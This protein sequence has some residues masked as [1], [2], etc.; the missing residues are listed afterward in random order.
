MTYEPGK[1]A[2]Y[3]GFSSNSDSGNGDEV[4]L[5]EFGN[6]G[7]AKAEICRR[8]IVSTVVSKIDSTV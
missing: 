6:S 4:S 8:R 7:Y 1:H 3:D 2:S 5:E